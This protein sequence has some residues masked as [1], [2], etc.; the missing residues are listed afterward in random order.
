[1]SVTSTSVFDKTNNIFDEAIFDTKL[2][3]LVDITV[4]KAVFDDAIFDSAIFDITRGG[5]ITFTDSAAQ[6]LQ[7]QR[8]ATENTSTSDSSGAGYIS[9]RS[10]TASAVNLTDNVTRILAGIRNV[11]QSIAVGETLSKITP[12]VARYIRDLGALF[13]SA[14]FGD[15]TTFDTATKSHQ[16]TDSVA[17]SDINKETITEPSISLS[18]SAARIY[19]SI[20]GLTE[21][22]SLSDNISRLFNAFRTLTPNVSVSDSVANDHEFFRAITAVSVSLSDNVSRIYNA[23]RA[24]SESI[25]L[26]DNSSRLFSA[27]R[28]LSQSVASS[29]SASGLATTF[30]NITTAT[31]NFSDSVA[32]SIGQ[33]RTL[34][35]ATA[36]AETLAG[37]KLILISIRKTVLLVTE[38]RSTKYIVT[39]TRATRQFIQKVRN[40]VTL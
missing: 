31:I 9:F 5:V 11:S 22:I 18:D 6:S 25:S 8:E 3:Y 34:T 28:T 23:I 4:S 1:M 29:D 27:L 30:R 12:S 10:I 15:S 39:A 7:A 32:K 36:I 19:N 35:E 40:S 21:S 20:R 24:A 38:L 16:I 33:Y 13:D 17:R 26:S 2:Q 37:G 14:L